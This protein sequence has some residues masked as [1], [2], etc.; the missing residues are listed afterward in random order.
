MDL[1]PAPPTPV[2]TADPHC[3]YRARALE[4]FATLE[5]WRA[6]LPL[7]VKTCVMYGKTLDV[8][9]MECW[10]SDAGKPY[11][12]GG[13]TEHPK[14][15]TPLASK[16]MLAVRALTGMDFD[17]CFVNYYRDGSDTIGWHADD[18]SW[19]GPEIASVSFGSARRFVMKPKDKDERRAEFMLGE[20]DVLQMHDCQRTWIHSVPRQ[21]AAVGPR[22]NFTFRQTV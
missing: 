16:L 18:D 20:G 6:D 19:I 1:F 5:Q 15:W 7:E 22:V 4:G 9:R 2:V 12:F 21:A 13:R 8:P 10:F 11:R 17:S 14:P 3:T